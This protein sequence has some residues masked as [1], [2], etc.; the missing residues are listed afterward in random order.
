MSGKFDLNIKS[1]HKLWY[2]YS[3]HQQYKW[4]EIWWCAWYFLPF[5][6][7]HIIKRTLYT[8][9][10]IVVQLLKNKNHYT[11]ISYINYIWTRVCARVPKSLN[12]PNILRKTKPGPVKSFMICPSVWINI[13]VCLALSIAAFRVFVHLSCRFWAAELGQLF[14]SSSAG[15][16][17]DFHWSISHPGPPHGC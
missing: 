10:K 8:N 11:V 15:K 3:S 16:W 5:N 14:V 17:F 6:W 9:F 4:Y 12:L 13:S 1:R 2:L 7:N